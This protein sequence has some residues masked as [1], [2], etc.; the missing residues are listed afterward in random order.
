[1][2]EI[3]KQSEE[4]LLLIAGSRTFYDYN[5]MSTVLNKLL[6]NI[7]DKN[8]TIIEGGAKGADSLAGKY[9][10]EHNYNLQVVPA[11]W[12]KYGKSAGYKRNKE[13]H[14][15]IAKCPNRGV[16]YFLDGQS[17][18]TMHNF[19]LAKEYNNPLK[20]YDYVKQQFVIGT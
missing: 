9:A 6:A 15:I 11:E 19:K 8:I 10:K 20:I 14:E 3:N 1:M 2:S 12:N 17:K 13:M 5:L 18:G 7:K 4:F 16:V